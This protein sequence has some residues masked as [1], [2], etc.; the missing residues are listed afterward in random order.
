MKVIKFYCNNQRLT[1]YTSGVITESSYSYLKFE[2]NFRTEDWDAVSTKT[3]VFNYKGNIYE[4]ELDENNQCYVPKEVLKAPSFSVYLCGNNII[5]NSIKVLVEATESSAT[6]IDIEKYIQQKIQEALSGAITAAKTVNI[7]LLASNWMQ[8]GDRHAQIVSIA[9]ITPN[10]K[11]DLQPSSEQ[12][13]I[14]HEKDIAFTT[15]NHNG[16]VLVFVIGD[17]P[18]NDY[19]IQATIT[20]VMIDG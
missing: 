17:R 1:R 19:I 14:F 7:S 13:S 11:V 2:F 3:A 4:I 10:S 5:T 20:E 12:L 8:N 9:G 18:Q 6:D 15:E 16:T